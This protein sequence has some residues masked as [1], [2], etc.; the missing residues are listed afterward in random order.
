MKN[1]LSVFVGKHQGVPV[2]DNTRRV[3][4]IADRIPYYARV[5]C[6]AVGRIPVSTMLRSHFPFALPDGD[7]PAHL[8]IE[9]TNYCNLA[10]PYC[11]SPLGIRRRGM[12]DQLTFAILLNQIREF[13]LPRVRVVGNGEAT[14]HPRFCEMIRALA[15]SCRYLNLVTNGQCLDERMART[16]LEAPVRLLE[17]SADSDSKQEYE[18]S[19]VRGNFECLLANLKM[20]QKLKRELQSPTLINVRAM[21]R[22]SEYSREPGI[23]RFWARHADVAM[24]QYLHDYTRGNDADVFMHDQKRKGTI[25]RCSLP[26]KAMIVHWNGRVPICEM[27]QQQTGIPE[28]VIAG[29]IH[30]QSLREI[31]NSA[32]F[33][34]YRAGH[35]NRKPEL[36]P[37][38]SGCLGG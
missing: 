12:M 1:M 17:I 15:G 32:L 5:I 18:R 20:L 34:Q 13:G 38:C 27:S 16:I 2:L 14:L 37:I 9:F 31:W 29:D 35:R 24:P 30:E 4:R 23:I 21:I 6:G 7:G 22:P 33:V 26:T 19:R 8:T 11:T 36:T 10:C 28:G 25:P 3:A